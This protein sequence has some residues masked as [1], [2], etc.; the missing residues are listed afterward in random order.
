MAK[1]YRGSASPQV[2]LCCIIG[3]DPPE[4]SAAKLVST[5]QTYA[6]HTFPTTTSSGQPLLKWAEVLPSGEEY[7]KKNEDQRMLGFLC[8]S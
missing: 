2:K 5:R 8:F 6:T 7:K 3:V 1:P 4:V